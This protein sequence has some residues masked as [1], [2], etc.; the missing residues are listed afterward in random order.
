MN[1]YHTTS[2]SVEKEY[3]AFRTYC[4]QFL[5]SIIVF[6][7]VLINATSANGQ[8]TPIANAVPGIS[9]HY[10][11]A[12]GTNATGV[13]YN[14]NFNVYYAAIAGNPGFPLETFDA[15]GNPLYQTNTG[16][17]MR[18]MWWNPNTNQVESNGYNTGGIWAYDVNGSGYA[19]NTGTSIFTGYNQPTVQSVGDYNCADN[20][21]IYYNA[22]QIM[23]R[24]RATNALI[25][26]LNITGLPVV[27]TNLNN[28]SVFY[29]DCAGHEIGL[30]DY[31]NKAVYFVDKTTGAYSGMSQLPAGT[32]TNVSFRA[33]WANDMVWVYD[34]GTR[35]WYSFQV[36]TGF[37]GT[38]SNPVAC[39]PPNLVT[40]DQT[41]C[42]PNTIDLNNSINVSSDPG[43]ATF[44]AT[45]ADA[46]AA[47]N[48][49]S[50]TV[51]T[52]GTYYIRYEDPSDPTCFSTGSVLITINP[53]Y[54]LTENLNACENSVV[55]YPDGSSETI[56][57][58]TSHTSNLTTVAGCDSI[59]VTNITMDPVYSVSENVNVCSGSNYTYPDGTTSTSITVNESHTSNLVTT[60]GCDSIVV[61]NI[62]V[63]PLPNS[64]TNGSINFCSTDA[65]T[66]ITSVLG[67]PDTGG[68][69]S[70]AM[71]SGTGV[72]DPAT[73]APGTYTYT[74]T[75]PCGT[76]SS[77]V[78]VTVQAAPN[79]G[80]NGSMSFCDTDPSSD[81]Y[82]ALG[83]S[84]DA[85]GTWSPAMASGTGVFDPSADAGGTYTY[86]V[87]NSCGTSTATVD[88]TVQPVPDPGTNGSITL[89]STDASVD[90]FTLLG[91]SP[92]AGGT[93]S[94]A[95]NSGTGVFDPATDTGGTYTYTLTSGCGT[96]TSQVDVT[97]N[98][99]DDASF[100]YSSSSFCIDDTNPTPTIS[101]TAAGTFTISGS[102][103]INSSTGEIDLTA[104]GAGSYTVTYSTSGVCPDTQTFSVSIMNIAD[105]TI[106]SPSSFHCEYD[107]PFTLQAATPGGVWSGPGVD[108]NTGV[109]DPSQANAGFNTI[110]YTIP[111][112][113]GGV[114]SI[115]I[116]VTPTPTVSTIPDTTINIGESVVLTTTGSAGDYIWTPS[117]WLDCD[118]CVSPV[119]TPEDTIVYMVT[120][121]DN[122]C[123]AS[124]IV[125]VNV[126]YE[127]VVFVPNIFSPNGDNHNDVLYVRG[128]GIE[129]M[130]FK[131]YDRWGEKVFESTEQNFGW[132]GTFRGKPM[133]PAVF[134]YYVDVEFTDGTS[135]LLKGDVT[136]IR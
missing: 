78:I 15:A 127:P 110:T 105:P 130:L 79:A 39:V 11:Q 111:G 63:D 76:S 86:T 61:T 16:F 9:L 119:T 94:P 77:D 65:A 8:C 7:A 135:T 114:S 21:I 25:G 131:V 96:F 75:N 55:V 112:A 6:T 129:R 27:T 67:S 109:F 47:T 18:G 44:Y 59:I 37:N 32:I 2:L 102:G 69:W 71:T 98:I 106:L 30:L 51:S 22:G 120:V 116:N 34:T 91:G 118:D 49:I 4:S 84:P 136:L 19:L 117:T 66:D 92:D 133:N 36:L 101:G 88:V 24:D 70:P 87:T 73:D 53:I 85:G 54:S 122:G 20:E 33:S 93:W 68:T 124:D 107:D 103:V 113:C 128:K 50:N 57:G 45:A 125:V 90:L 74:V 40:D 95:M 26:Y 132:D 97:L 99:A 82:N 1:P 43:N 29:T 35:T 123:T 38:C 126:I 48:P 83:G 14:P 56:T 17:D 42:S 104:S 134:V 28:N 52:S 108:P 41:T 31:I 23:R 80:T 60:Q 89:C 10:V 64:G 5:L 13:A 121:D 46:S 115:Q 12:G 72:F 58:N 62:T 81:L 100:S 3:S